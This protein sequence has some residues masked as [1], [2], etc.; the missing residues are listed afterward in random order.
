MPG[1][2]S[3][4]SKAHQAHIALNEP[5]ISIVKQ[6]LS[7]DLS[8]TFPSLNPHFKPTFGSLTLCQVLSGGRPWQIEP[9]GE[10]SVTSPSSMGSVSLPPNQAAKRGICVLTTI[11]SRR[12]GI[13]PPAVDPAQ[14]TRPITA[15]F[16]IQTALLKANLRKFYNQTALLRANLRKSSEITFGPLTTFS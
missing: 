10:E 13:Q 7:Q 11:Q 8:Q 12:L 16:L 1:L 5:M 15:A 6:G 3:K 4:S 2:K 9:R 14:S